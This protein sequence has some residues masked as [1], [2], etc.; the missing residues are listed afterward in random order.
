MNDPTQLPADHPIHP[1]KTYAMYQAVGDKLHEKWDIVRQNLASEGLDHFVIPVLRWEGAETL[2]KKINQLVHYKKE[3]SGQDDW[4]LPADTIARQTGDCEDFAIVKYALLM[5]AGVPEDRMMIVIGRIASI[6]AL[7]DGFEEHA[8]L[9]IDPFG[10]G[11]RVLDNKFDKLITPDYYLTVNFTP[12]KAIS[13]D[14]VYLF[15]GKPF[16]MAD[17]DLPKKG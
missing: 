5:K 6:E 16:A 14:K 1:F 12:I 3:L 8:F 2:N 11:P 17:I 13:G 9:V 7:P 10:D 15:T 4:Q